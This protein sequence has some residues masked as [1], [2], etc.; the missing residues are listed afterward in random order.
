MVNIL[1]PL[2]SGDNFDIW[3]VITISS[4]ILT[5]VI[6][7]V[8][9]NGSREPLRASCELGYLLVIEFSQLLEIGVLHEL[10]GCPALILVINQHFWNDVL[11]IWRDMWY[12]VIKAF[13]LLWREIYLHMSCMSPEIIKDFLRGSSKHFM[14]LVNLVELVISWKQRTEGEDFVHNATNAPDIHFVTVI[15]ICQ[16]TLWCSVPSGRNI[17]C[18]WLVLVQAPTTTKISQFHNFAR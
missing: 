8:R 2:N 16:K 11:A 6:S 14:D 13:K 3:G 9:T 18:E 4:R 15:A 12:Q 7:Q 10:G 1:A 17:L 5:Q